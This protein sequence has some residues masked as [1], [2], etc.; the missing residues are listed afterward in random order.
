MNS[1][2]NDYSILVSTSIKGEKIPLTGKI[3]AL[4]AFFEVKERNVGI[5]EKYR[6]N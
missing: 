2:K 6:V 1:L 4:T 5:V 3:T